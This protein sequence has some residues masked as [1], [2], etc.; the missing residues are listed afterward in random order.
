V[1]A[2][3]L[4]MIIGKTT[5][6]N[7]LSSKPSE[8]TVRQTNTSLSP[9]QT[10][11]SG[12]SSG[13]Q[14]SAGGGTTIYTS[15]SSQ[16]TPTNQ[17]AY[18]SSASISGYPQQ[19][20][21]III[22]SRLKEGETVNITG[23]KLKSNKGTITIPQAVEIYDPSGFTPSSDIILKPGN[24]VELYSLTSPLNRNL[25]LNKCMGYLEQ[26]YNFQ[27]IYLPSNCPTFSSSEIRY[28]SGQCQSYI[29]S[30]GYCKIPDASFY[31]SLPGSDEGNTCRE[32]LQNIG[33][34][35]CFRNHK[36]DSDFLSNNW[37]VW[38]DQQ[39]IN[40]DSQHDYLRLYDKQGNLV[41]E[42][43]Y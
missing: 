39:N 30:L 40:L 6:A 16:A 31:N 19:Y 21:R 41:S 7:T 2:I 32:F 35:S 23:W 15:P 18:I 33:Y 29:W 37:I 25:R 22:Y 20:T 14:V 26:T 1:G 17:R 13:G 4:I 24:Y 3:F 34:G 42:Y 38:L 36:T 12:G 8:T 9:G 11:V 28:L 43:N 27:P 10:S 5:P